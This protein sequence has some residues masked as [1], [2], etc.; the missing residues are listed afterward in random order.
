MVR[1]AEWIPRDWADRMSRL[2]ADG[3]SDGATWIGSLPTLIGASL[4]E[5]E[6]MVTG[7]PMTGW[8]SVVLPVERDGAPLAL[9][10]CW[11]HPEAG[12]EHLALRRWGGDGA[13]RLVAASP[14]R[15]SL[16]LER[17]HTT[18]LMREWD[19][20]A[21]AVIGGL[22][23]RLHVPALPS[24]RRL[25][26][27]L[28]RQTG[29]YLTADAAVPR[30]LVQHGLAL[31]RELRDDPLIDATLLH[32]DLHFQNVL[33]ADREPWLAIDPK[34]MA[35][36]PGWEIAPALFNRVEEMGTGGSLRWSVRRRVELVCDELGLDEEQA[37]AWTLLRLITEAAADAA[38]GDDQWVSTK[39][40]IV[41]ALT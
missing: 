9:K 41:K 32:G 22:A 23:R 18:N 20:D 31:H 30:R 7:P 25:S 28:D 19:E 29:D 1:A 8:T 3:G 37:R 38:T 34:P 35:G 24:V 4:A 21:V 5:W 27:L 11:P 16:L 39:I 13:V 2:P 6:L 10:T 15:G 40:S 33:A 14:A 26:A 17:L 36:H 12:G